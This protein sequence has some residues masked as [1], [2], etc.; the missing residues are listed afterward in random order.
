[1]MISG[2]LSGA[3]RGVRESLSRLFSK[4]AESDSG[5]IR[6]VSRPA[7]ETARNH[8]TSDREG[9]QSVNSQDFSHDMADAPIAT[10][11]IS[12][13]EYVSRGSNIVDDLDYRSIH[14]LVE[15]RRDDPYLSA[16]ERE[17]AS[18]DGDS[19]LGAICRSQGF[20]DLPTVVE[21]EG[22]D[23]VIDAGGHEFFR[24]LT[25]RSY[26]EQFKHGSYFPGSASHVLDTGNGTYVSTARSD[27]LYYAG[28]NEDAVVRMALR[29]GSRTIEFRD[30]HEE[31]QAALS[32]I[33]D[34]AGWLRGTIRITENPSPEMIRRSEELEAKLQVLADPGRYA[35]AR[36][37]QA[38]DTG[39]TGFDHVGNYWVVLDR[40]ALVVQR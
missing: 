11:G 7:G 34:E 8:E 31:H 26:A 36:G 16:A 9:E 6:D 4:S 13:S 29:P 2:K 25:D 21:R 20:D 32:R 40:T 39:R 37:Y 22:V 24:G 19:A 30:L 15:T 12:T 1:M 23:A 17:A 14:T 10:T 28:N 3:M 35:A 38:Y 18:S 5:N 27:A 33:S